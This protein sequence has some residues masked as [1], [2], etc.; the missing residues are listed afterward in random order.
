MHV[1]ICPFLK[2]EDDICILN[3]VNFRRKVNIK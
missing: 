1:K 2:N 3:S